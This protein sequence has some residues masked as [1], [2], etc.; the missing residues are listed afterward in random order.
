MQNGVKL[1]GNKIYNNKTFHKHISSKWKMQKTMGLLFKG[2][3][4]AVAKKAKIFNAM[5]LRLDS[6]IPKG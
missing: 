3:R 1:T 6:L 5:L 4:M 2:T